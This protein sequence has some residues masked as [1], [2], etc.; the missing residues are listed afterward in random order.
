LI[1]V[2]VSENGDGGKGK[3]VESRQRTQ[4][5]RSGGGAEYC[6]PRTEEGVLVHF[7]L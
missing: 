2:E 1:L 6:I 3:L 5:Q 7:L 4:V